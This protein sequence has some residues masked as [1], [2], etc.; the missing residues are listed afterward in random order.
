[1]SQRREL[2]EPEPAL[3]VGLVLASTLALG[4]LVTTLILAV[5]VTAVLDTLDTLY[6]LDT[7][8]GFG[9]GRSGLIVSAPSGLLHTYS[10]A[11][12]RSPGSHMLF[13]CRAFCT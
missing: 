6:T 12:M 10:N 11:P 3:V 5:V 1:M 2:L 4:V 8:E 9:H 7:G 13:D